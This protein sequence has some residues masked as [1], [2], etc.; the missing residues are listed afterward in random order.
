MSGGGDDGPELVSVSQYERGSGVKVGEYKRAPPATG[1]KREKEEEGGAE[2]PVDAKTTEE[3]KAKKDT[4]VPSKKKK[5]E[6]EAPAAAPPK[7]D[8]QPASSLPKMTVQEYLSLDLKRMQEEINNRA[9]GKDAT[10][11]ELAGKDAAARIAKEG[12]DAANTAWAEKSAA[13]P[14]AKPGFKE[15]DDAIVQHCRASGWNS[16]AKSVVQNMRNHRYFDDGEF[17]P[18][19]LVPHLQSAGLFSLAKDVMSKKYV[20][21]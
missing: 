20:L 11:N 16:N 8:E 10:L 2:P 15:L 3:K 14:D 17:G 18:K 7:T 21:Q 13:A 6:K 1:K 19:S 12:E 9:I 4:P 5:D